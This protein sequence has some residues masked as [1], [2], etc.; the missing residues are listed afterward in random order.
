MKMVFKD[1]D[2][3]SKDDNGDSDGE[4]EGNRNRD[5]DGDGNSEGDVP[6]EI[7]GDNNATAFADSDGHTVADDNDGPANFDE[8]SGEKI[9]VRIYLSRFLYSFSYTVLLLNVVHPQ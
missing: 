1:G 9:K 7:D 4:G 6:K 2:G 5:S 3:H 8:F